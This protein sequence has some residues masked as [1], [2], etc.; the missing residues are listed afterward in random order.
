M[1][2]QIEDDTNASSVAITYTDPTQT[3]HCGDRTVGRPVHLL[4]LEHSP[5]LTPLLSLG[6]YSGVQDSK[7]G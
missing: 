1:Q 7:P 3:V 6:V 5:T 4:V 2:A